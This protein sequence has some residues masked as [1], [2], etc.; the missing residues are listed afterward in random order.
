MDKLPNRAPV[1]LVDNLET[2]KVL[3]DPT[4]I[5]ILHILT[6]E[7]QSINQVAE[8]MGL[9]SS[10]LY[11]HFKI[12]EEH[13]LI[14]VVHTRMVNNILEKFYWSTAVDIDIDQTLLDFS[15]EGGKEN[16]E[17]L[18]SS[19][20]E[21]TR[22]DML[23]TLQVRKENLTA[24]AAS[25]PREMIITNVKKKLKDE[26]FQAY[27]KQLKELLE[28]FSKLPEETSE[29]EDINL[30]SLAVYA[31]PNYYYDQGKQENE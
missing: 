1:F 22:M 17:R 12:L 27:I 30:F 8:K 23:R 15:S 13:Q 25:I 9:S 16:I 5:E 19:S 10:R 2:L 29:G 20:L 11:Y 14:S 3:T 4:R 21:T 18:V 28:E 7:P 31:Y 6:P 24:G 26:T